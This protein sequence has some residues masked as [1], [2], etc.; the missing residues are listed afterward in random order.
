MNEHVDSDARV[1]RA[2]SGP[3]LVLLHGEFGDASTYW[4]PIVGSVSEHFDLILPDLPGFGESP[5]LADYRPQTYLFWLRQLA[6]AIGPETSDQPPEPA[7]RS[8]ILLGGAG[9]GATLARLFAARYY[10]RVSRLILS[11]GGTL[12]RPSRL[13][14]LFS[15]IAPG[16]VGG[17]RG[18]GPRS[19]DDLFYDPFRHAGP[20]F[21]RALDRTRPA[22]ER[23]LQACHEAPLPPQLTP[24]CTTLLLWG[25]EDRYCPL[26]T[27]QAIVGEIGDT[28]QVDIFEAGHMVT[29]EQP[30]RFSAHLIDFAASRG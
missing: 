30:H 23:V 6:D 28:R 3:P 25:N 29:I 15:R 13:R 18:G 16:A 24:M 26:A 19:A 10:T 12:E 9:F 20:E 5:S 8:Q 11:G 21:R 7:A 2:G 22:R 27:Q 1:W 4:G 17:K 14:G